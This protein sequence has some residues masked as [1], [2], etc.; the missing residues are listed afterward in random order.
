MTTPPDDT[1]ESGEINWKLLDSLR[2]KSHP[3]LPNPG[4]PDLPT[5]V[6]EVLQEARISQNLLDMIG[7]PL[8]R[9]D[10]PYERDLD[11]RTYLA[12][13]RVMDLEERL[14]RIGGWHARETAPGGMVGDYCVTCGD[15]WPCDTYR[16]ATTGEE[17]S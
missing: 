7:I 4:P 2:D 13:R 1:T 11:A 14:S 5:G 16:M 10:H 12:V 8:G 6:G 17:R 15:L 9:P 3:N